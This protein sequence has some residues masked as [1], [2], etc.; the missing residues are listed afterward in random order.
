MSKA[1]NNEVVQKPDFMS[2]TD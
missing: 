2:M 1:E